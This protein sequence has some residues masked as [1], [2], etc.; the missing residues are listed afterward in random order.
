MELPEALRRFRKEFK[1]TQ[2]AAASVCGVT[3]RVYQS[4]E[5]GKVTPSISGLIALALHFGTS[6]D[7]LCG[8]SD[9]PARK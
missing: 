3:E 4:Y 5:Y 7:Y 8:L 6:L 1:V 2:K 9:D